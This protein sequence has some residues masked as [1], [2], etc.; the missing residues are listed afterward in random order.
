MVGAPRGLLMDKVFHVTA[1][2][3]PAKATSSDF[4]SPVVCQVRVTAGPVKTTD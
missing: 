1:S 4:S 3:S 2:G